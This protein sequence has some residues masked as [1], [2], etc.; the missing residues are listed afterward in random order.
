MLPTKTEDEKNLSKS[1]KRKRRL[2]PEQC[3]TTSKVMTYAS[4]KDMN[5]PRKFYIILIRIGLYHD[6]KFKLCLAGIQ[7]S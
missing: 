5:L 2:D 4:K 6:R 7:K 1:E 3:L